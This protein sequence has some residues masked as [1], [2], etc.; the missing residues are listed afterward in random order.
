[1]ERKGIA[2]GRKD[3]WDIE[4]RGVTERLLDA[5]GNFVFVILRLDDGN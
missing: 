5:T 4:G 1:M 3:K 2:I